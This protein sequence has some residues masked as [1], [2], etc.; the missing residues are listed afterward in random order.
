V[1]DIPKDNGIDVSKKL[2]A[3]RVGFAWR[4]TENF[5]VR[6]GYGITYN[7]L[8]F[9]RPLRGLYPATIGATFAR[10][11][12]FQW[13]NRLEQGIPP[14][15][16]PDISSGVIPLPPTID[17]GPRSP[18]GGMLDRGYTQSWN[19]T[20]ERKLPLDTVVSA[21]YVGTQTTHQLADLDINAAPPGTGAAG[22]PLFASQGRRIDANMWDG[23]LSSNYHSLQVA[24]NKRLTRGLLLKGAYTWS[25]AM[26]MAD[27]DGWVGMPETD[28]LPA[29]RRN[30]ARAGYDRAH[31]FTMGWM[32]ELPFGSG[33][34]WASSGV[35]S[36]IIGGWQ[37]NGGFA[38]YTGTPFTIRASDA[39][40]NAPSSNQTADQVADVRKIGAI[41]PGTPF[42]D[43]S[44]FATP[45]RSAT[46]GNTIRNYLR[47]P[48][49]VNIDLSVFRSFSLSERLRLEFKAEAFNATNTPH[50]NN[51][52]ANV[53]TTANFMTVTGAAA[54]ERQFRFGLRLA[55]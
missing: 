23:W 22:R 3:P 32:Y 40:L 54:D 28:W 12:S 45:S 18:W 7:P 2:F 33:K 42:Y 11:G 46:F 51:P 6:S 44:S 38:A 8:P 36:A 52:N 49:R 1:G 16:V 48:G 27:D 31:M 34:K 43:P 47:G 17:M 50:F 26:N 39:L 55:F 10:L 21:G 24:L 4:A 9:A 29:I 5:V 14:I 19:V 20:L 30:Y 15:A 53:S 37:L 13:F 25:K 41:G 35:S